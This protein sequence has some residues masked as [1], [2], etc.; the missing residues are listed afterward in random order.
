M[1]LIEHGADATAQNNDGTT[2]LHHMSEWGDVDV[3]QLLIKHGADAT[4]QS[5]DGMTL[6]HHT[7]EWGDVLIEHSTNVTA[8]Q[9]L[10]I[11]G[12]CRGLRPRH[13]T[14]RGDRTQKSQVHL[15]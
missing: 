11:D 2:P 4:A 12:K 9:G 14:L 10:T 3:D 8:H 1:L 7:S 15:T 5:N 13:P 6:L